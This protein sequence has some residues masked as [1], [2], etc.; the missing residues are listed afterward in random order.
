ML[1]CNTVTSLL[2]YISAR[3]GISTFEQFASSCAVIIMQRDAEHLDRLSC[4]DASVYNAS[5]V[6]VSVCVLCVA[7][8]FVSSV[9]RIYS[10]LGNLHFKSIQIQNTF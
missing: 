3:F 8:L 7:C 6:C 10:V 4:I 2:S 1:F 9:V 5:C